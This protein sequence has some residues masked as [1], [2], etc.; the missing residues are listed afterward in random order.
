MNLGE[1][2]AGLEVKSITPGA[3]RIRICDLTEDS[4]TVLPGSLFVA[5]AGLKADGRRYLRDAIHAGAVAILLQ[6]ESQAPS[7]GTDLNGAALIVATDVQRTSAL[8]AERFYGLP[9]RKLKVVGVTGTNGKTTTTYL[10]WQL[11]NAT[12]LRCGLVG[13]VLIDDGR[14]IAPAAMTTPPAIELSRTL[15]EMVESGCRAVALEASSHSLHQKRVD[16]LAFDVG[17]FTNL[18]GDH[19]DYHKTMDA[20]ADA[21]ARLFEMLPPEGLAVVNADDPAAERMLRDCSARTLRAGRAGAAAAGPSAAEV[22]ITRA[23]I[24]GMHLR[25]RGPWGF[26]ETHVPLIG[27]YNAMNVLQAVACGQEL[28]MDTDQ[29]RAAL[30]S[31]KAPPGRLEPVE[32]P[33]GA[34]PHPAPRVFVDYAHTDDALKNV[35]TAVREGMKDGPG[36]LWAVFGCGGDKDRT[37]RPRMG[38]VASEIADRVIVTSDNPRSENPRD[39][40]N[41]IIEGIRLARRAGMTVHVEREE[42]INFAIR[43][44]DPADV[45]II[46]GKGHETEQIKS[47]GAGGLVSTHFDDREVARAALRHRA[48]A[49]GL[50]KSG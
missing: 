13:T 16:A 23:D 12:K 27:A 14:E 4:R 10:I 43:E 28:G 19:L 37:K 39:I 42:A 18:T 31:I 50:A 21:K 44:A 41:Q 9:S 1:L 7:T 29:L 35:L 24:S 15:A 22:E 47:D 45:I 25:L 30:P 2:I 49:R 46:A 34:H 33:H 32:P 11:L 5:R 38:A 20:Y 8:L 3:E 6:S 17:V 36:K 48:R 26:I 40:V